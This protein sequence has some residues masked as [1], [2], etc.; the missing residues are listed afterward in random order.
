M[1]STNSN[2]KVVIYPWCTTL[3]FLALL[4]SVHRALTAVCLEPVCSY[5]IIVKLRAPC[6]VI[7]WL[8]RNS[9]VADKSRDTFVQMQ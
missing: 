2:F 4:S 6:S 5:I 7:G 9:A 3:R 8:S 1:F